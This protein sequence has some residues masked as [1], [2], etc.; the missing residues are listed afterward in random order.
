MTIKFVPLLQRDTYHRIDT[1]PFI[2][3]HILTLFLMMMADEEDVW[4]S[5]YFLVGVFLHS[6]LFLCGHWSTRMRVRIQY[7]PLGKECN[8][9]NLQQATHL[10]V[11]Y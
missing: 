1:A 5:L 11:E 3:V 6:F 8:L 2:I 4:S 10:Y 9:Q 7:K